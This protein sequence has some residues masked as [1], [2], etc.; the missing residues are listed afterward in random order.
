MR[1]V[2]YRSSRLLLV[3]DAAASPI[4]LGKPKSTSS[5]AG[6]TR[7]SRLAGRIKCTNAGMSRAAASDNKEDPMKGLMDAIKEDQAKM[8]P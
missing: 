1:S 3:A 4:P 7:R 2:G 5:A 8:K 6:P